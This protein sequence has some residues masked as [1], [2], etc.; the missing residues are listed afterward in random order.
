MIR[1]VRSPFYRGIAAGLIVTLT[2][3]LGLAGY[4]R[5]AFADDVSNA[6]SAGA[7]FGRDMYPSAPMNVDGDAN[8]GFEHKDKDGNPKASNFSSA[9]GIFGGS[10][11]GSGD[12]SS[13][14]NTEGNGAALGAASDAR[15]SNIES[16]TDNTSRAYSTFQKSQDRSHPDFANDPIVTSSERLFNDLHT[17]TANCASGTDKVTD[18]QSC[19]RNNM[20]KA[21]EV[22]REVYYTPV[23]FQQTVFKWAGC[24]DHSKMTFKV[25]LDPSEAQEK[26]FIGYFIDRETN[27]KH[28]LNDDLKFTTVPPTKYRYPDNEGRYPFLEYNYD[29][30][31]QGLYGVLDTDI[32]ALYPAVNFSNVSKRGGNKDDLLGFAYVYINPINP[33]S[34]KKYESDGE[35]VATQINFS[36]THDS[37]ARFRAGGDGISIDQLPTE[38]NDYTLILDMNDEGVST[39]PTCPLYS[40]YSTDQARSRGHSGSAWGNIEVV[41]NFTGY[42]INE[43]IREAPENCETAPDANCPMVFQCTDDNTRTAGAVDEANIR[44]HL[45]SMFAGDNPQDTSQPICYAGYAASQ[46]NAADYGYDDSKSCAL[47]QEKNQECGFISGECAA[48]QPNGECAYY[49]NVYD[50][51]HDPDYDATCEMRQQF[52]SEFSACDST[53]T[54]STTTNDYKMQDPRSCEIIHDLTSCQIKRSFT[55]NLDPSQPDSYQDTSYPAEAG[56]DPCVAEPDGFAKSV[57]WVCNSRVAPERDGA[58]NPLPSPYDPLYP[59]DDGYCQDATATYDTTF[60]YQQMEC[61]TDIYGDVQCPQGTPSNVDKNTCDDLEAQGCTR[62]SIQCVEGGSASNGYCYLEEAEYDCGYDVP[63]TSTTYETSHSCPSP[64]RCM[65]D[66][67]F[68]A[69]NENNP[70]FGEAMAAMNAVQ[71]AAQDGGCD[72]MGNCEIF[73]GTAYECKKAVGGYQN[74]CINPG[75][76]GLKEYLVL[77]QAA[78]KMSGAVANMEAVQA[79]AEPLRGA[80]TSMTNAAKG[81]YNKVAEKFFTSAVENIDPAST[82]LGSSTG[83]AVTN[84]IVDKTAEFIGNTFGEATRDALF[85]TEG[86]VTKFGGGEAWLGNTMGFIAAAYFYYQLAVLAIQIIWKC[87][88]EEYELGAKKDLKVCSKV[89]SYCAQEVLGACVEKREAYCCYNSPLGRIIQ[90]QAMPQLGRSYGSAKNPQC[91]ALTMSEFA[92]LD[93]SQIDLTEWIAMLTENGLMPDADPNTLKGQYS[94][95]ALSGTGSALANDQDRDHV[96]ERSIDRQPGNPDQFNRDVESNI[97]HQQ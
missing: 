12:W 74:C 8:I 30:S 96:L 42:Y 19:H 35:L 57:N 53:T 43:I 14:E 38:D 75:G 32:Q 33:E 21:C 48:Y 76:P 95:E 90:E 47:N 4:S 20:V 45:T 41:A 11:S 7:T 66:E 59:G 85:S 40:A 67:C 9:D 18:L 29:G 44:P 15:R 64:I 80:W 71:F 6:A 13:L 94:M 89:G 70:S 79:Y 5:P 31:P 27:A 25:V 93:W 52:L 86:G 60:Y 49:E 83:G 24:Y 34:N 17:G 88:E 37:V 36:I 23:S 84:A 2:A 72:E 78:G 61:Y 39:Q 1:D 97:R 87:E 3:M 65:G 26:E 22:K 28:L 69:E 62:V 16:G 56:N 92:A 77:L 73:P 50:C 58:G 91:P 63:I 55:P 54:A 81:T 68:D 82:G 46:C 51:G 10:V